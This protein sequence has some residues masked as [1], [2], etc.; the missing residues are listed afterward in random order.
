MYLLATEQQQVL[1]K[2]HTA[3]RLWTLP[4]STPSSVLPIV[5]MRWFKLRGLQ[6][7][8]QEEAWLSW[9]QS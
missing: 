4:Y 1:G 9:A 2:E 5:P 8:S 6:G 3:K 7:S